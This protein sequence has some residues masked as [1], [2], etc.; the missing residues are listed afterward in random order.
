MP[1]ES[2]R[3]LWFYLDRA[4]LL[5]GVETFELRP[6]ISPKEPE[7]LALP[8]EEG[9]KTWAQIVAGFTK[10]RDRKYLFA[11]DGSIIRRSVLVRKESLVGLGKEGAKLAARLKLGKIAGGTPSVFIDWKRRLLAMGRVEARRLGLSWRF[12]TRSKAKLKAGTLPTSGAAV[13][14]LKKALVGAA[15][16]SRIYAD[17]I[18]R[19]P[20]RQW[21]QEAKPVPFGYG[22]AQSL[23]TCQ[24]GPDGIGTEHRRG[25]GQRTWWP[26]CRGRFPRA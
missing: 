5:D 9:T 25:P 18:R 20:A 1:A 14:R 19:E 16:V 17:E 23:G 11:E 22:A 24:E 6:F 26:P 15:S 12:V 3:A 4:A 10:H 21:V 7:W 13:R 2:G 8:E